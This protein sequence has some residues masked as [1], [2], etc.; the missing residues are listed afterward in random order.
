MENC[1]DKLPRWQLLWP[2]GDNAG[3]LIAWTEQTCRWKLKIV[4][5][6]NQAAG[7]TAL[8]RRWVVECTISWVNNHRRLSKDYECWPETSQA[9][10]HLSMIN[11]VTQTTYQPRTHRGRPQTIRGFT[12]TTQLSAGPLKMPD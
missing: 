2:D 3:Q 1:C 6:S 11:V 8:L 10:I 12:S 4:K 9:L 5:R 7:F